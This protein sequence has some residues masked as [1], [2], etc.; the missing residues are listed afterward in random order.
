MNSIDLLTQLADAVRQSGADI[1]P[2]YHEYMPMAFGIANSCGEAGRQLF[3]QL[4]APSPRYRQADAD[5]LYSNALRSGR[6]SNS[7]GTVW[8]LAER[9][10]VDLRQVARPEETAAPYTPAA[11]HAPY[12]S[13]TPPPTHTCARTLSTDAQPPEEEVPDDDGTDEYVPVTLPVHSWPDFLMQGIRC[14][15]NQA[16]CDVL[17]LSM[18]ATLG[19]TAAPLVSFHYGNR[20]LHPCL[21]VFIIAPPASGKG[22]MG[23]ARRLAQPIHD[24]LLKRYEQQCA[25][26]RSEKQKWDA[27]GKERTNQPE[28]ERPKRKL[29]FVAGDNTGTGILEN[30]IDQDGL[31]MI[32]ESEASVLSA[33][34]A[35]DYGNW[36]HTL[37][38]AF[39]HDGL[40][41]NRRTNYEHRE[42]HRTLLTV[43][44]SGTPGQVRP[45][46]PSA[47]NGLFSRELFYHMPPIT[48][49]VSQ[50][51]A[52]DRDYNTLFEQWGERWKRVLGALQKEVSQLQLT[53]TA[54]QK[55][56][57]DSQLAQLFR[58]GGATY[59]NAMRS[60]VA[61]MA[62]NLLR[63]M[64]ITA[65]LRSLDGLLTLTDETQLT[66]RLERLIPTLLSLPG[67]RAPMG[68]NADNLRDGVWSVL[69]MSVSDSD[70]EAVMA[71][72][73]PLY[74]HSLHVLSLMPEERVEHREG[75]K[76]QRFVGALG[77]TFTRQ[78]ALQTA[79]SLG[80]SE[81]SC[82]T[83]LRRLMDRGVIERTDPGEYR[84]SGDY[85]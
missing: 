48:Q 47:E 77:M 9:A 83:V 27:L 85:C 52:D 33:A 37:R 45:L 18:L 36:S 17:L 50:F 43:L 60:A 63:I 3:H 21:Q 70:F 1:A 35:S 11:P 69:E 31:G 15:S 25:V 8:H 5:K 53:L 4:C 38:K 75:S 16:Q 46:I 10:G 54:D 20:R 79:A 49:W 23:W 66:A 26:Y 81:K 59:G 2:T 40:S 55:Q 12:T 6:N 76:T 28:P 61:R 39:D 82:D 78:T 34:I 74:R 56:R 65:L 68:V 64:S 42:C 51:D 32:T 67:L 73:E 57:F 41:Y 29:F 84:F 30:L 58:H 13:L 19:A 71:M 80:W 7:L 14:G 62:I 44:I 72:A 22:A 24:D